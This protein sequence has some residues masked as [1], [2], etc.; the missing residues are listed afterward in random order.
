M[1]AG[2]HPKINNLG[3]AL[4]SQIDHIL[5]LEVPM[6]N[7]HR[8]QFPNAYQQIVPNA[9]GFVLTK[10]ILSGEHVVVEIE[11]ALEVL[12][13]DVVVGLGLEEV[14]YANDLVDLAGFLQGNHLGLVLLEGLL[15]R[16]HFELVHLL[17]GYLLPRFSVL[18]QEH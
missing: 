12:G 4:L 7:T 15:A 16:L 9:S 11:A 5:Q 8:M 1:K 2:G 17:Q 14:E 18:R 10:L 3:P 13:D 6:V